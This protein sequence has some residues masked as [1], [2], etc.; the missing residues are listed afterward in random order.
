MLRKVIKIVIDAVL[1]LVFLLM[2]SIII[3]SLAG[4]IFG[5]KPNGDAD[6]NGHILLAITV[7]ITLVFSVWFYKRVSIKKIDK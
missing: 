7:T 1:S 5:N 4:A 3:D 6:F 2:M